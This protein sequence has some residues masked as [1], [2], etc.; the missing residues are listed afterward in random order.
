MLLIVLMISLVISGCPK[1]IPPE[2]IVK[3]KTVYVFNECPKPEKPNYVQLDK[4]S[5]LGSA[6]N[7]NILIGNTMKMK[8]Y[9][10]SL[11]GAVQCY[12]DQSKEHNN[13]T[14]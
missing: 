10:D 3:I 8:S 9:T 5:H 12:E 4:T 7:I 2:P 14:D 13:V 11:L 6:Y 1:P